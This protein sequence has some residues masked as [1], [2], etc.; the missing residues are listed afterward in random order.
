MDRERQQL[1]PQLKRGHRWAARRLAEFA[2][3]DVVESLSGHFQLKDPDAYSHRPVS[4]R[5]TQFIS[6]HYVEIIEKFGAVES[7][8]LE[9]YRADLGAS[10]AA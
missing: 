8:T 2:S 7:A 5:M 6:D 3:D 4:P 9:K 10:I 1:L